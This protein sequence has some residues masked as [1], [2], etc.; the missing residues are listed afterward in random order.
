[1]VL[2]APAEA[3]SGTAPRELLREVRDECARLGVALVGGHTEVT[4]GLPRSIVVGTML[5]RVVSRPLTTGGLRPGDLVGMTRCAGLEGTAILLAERGER[6]AELHP[7]ELRPAAELLQE[8]WLSVVDAARLAAASPARD[9]AARRHRGRGGGG[10][11][12]AGRRVGVRARGRPRR[13]ARAG[14]R[15]R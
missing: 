14:R 10:A 13:G 1:M 4:P 5:G 6:L 8:G 3:P 15:R 12:R 2:L 9:G 7:G 11:P